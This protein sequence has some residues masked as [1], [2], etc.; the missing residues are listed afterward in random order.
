MG[1]L[2]IPFCASMGMIEERKYGTM[3]TRIN[4]RGNRY[5]IVGKETKI[6]H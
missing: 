2:F 6:K 4:L 5:E 3:E 1:V